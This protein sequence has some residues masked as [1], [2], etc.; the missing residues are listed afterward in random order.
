MI[1][2]PRANDIAS[3]PIGIKVAP[4]TAASDS[5]WAFELAAK[6]TSSIYL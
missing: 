3:I 4:T 6:I 2:Q 5:F 1:Q